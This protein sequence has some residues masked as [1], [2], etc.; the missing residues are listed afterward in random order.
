MQPGAA[1]TVSIVVP[2]QR[3]AVREANAHAW[4]IDAGRYGLS[5]AA[6]SCD[7]QAVSRTVTHAAR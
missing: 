5:E 7:P 2:A 1:R 4:R 3:F 6:S